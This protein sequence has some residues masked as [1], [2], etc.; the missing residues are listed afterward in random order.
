MFPITK[1][2]HF[3]Y[4]RQAS[5]TFYY[6]YYINFFSSFNSVI[7]L[8]QQ[9]ANTMKKFKLYHS[10]ASLRTVY[11][12]ANKLVRTWRNGLRCHGNSYKAW[13]LKL[14]ESGL[15]GATYEIAGHYSSRSSGMAGTTTFPKLLGKSARD[16]NIDKVSGWK[17]WSTINYGEKT[18]Y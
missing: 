6:Y 14:A 5:W 16:P 18:Y 11:E 17:E 2:I 3:V 8:L 1:L 4:L 12:T 9:L 10:A 15:P 7:I 13:L